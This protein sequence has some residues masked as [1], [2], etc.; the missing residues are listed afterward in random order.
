MEPFTC[1]Y[2]LQWEKWHFVSCFHHFDPENERYFFH[3]PVHLNELQ[4]AK[5]SKSLFVFTSVWCCL[6]NYCLQS[7]LYLTVDE[8][9]WHASHFFRNL[10][11][12]D[13]IWILKKFI[14]KTSSPSH[15]NHFRK[16]LSLCYFALNNTTS[17]ICDSQS[18][19][20]A[21]WTCSHGNCSV[22]VVFRLTNTINESLAHINVQSHAPVISWPQ[23]IWFWL[24]ICL[25]SLGSPT[26]IWD[27]LQQTPHQLSGA[28][29][30]LK[31]VNQNVLFLCWPWR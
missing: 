5:A 12:E 15:E 30:N 13:T 16:T 25:K 27:H 7:L 4:N 6:Q 10:Q 29:T 18:M 20:S 11:S 26:T 17:A 31:I 24:Y 9:V 1:I 14:Q 28:W 2:Y 19:A 8:Y 22:H 3:L 23:A 21:S